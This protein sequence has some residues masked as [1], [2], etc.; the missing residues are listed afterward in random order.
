VDK[1]IHEVVELIQPQCDRRRVALVVETADDMPP[2]PM[3]TAA[4]HQ[5]LMNVLTNAVEAAPERKGRITIRSRFLAEDSEAEISI[6][7]NG[8]GIGEHM[9]DKVFE[10]FASSKGQRG[11]GL[12][13]A[14]TRKLV[15]EHGGRIVLEP[16]AVEGD[17]GATFTITLPSDHSS[18]SAGETKLPQPL[19]ADALRD[20]F[21]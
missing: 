6:S 4:M 12:G 9:R 19:R 18:L 5:A 10:P 8:P 1:L 2:I 21:E 17:R 20:E 13:L 16:A 3:D 15:A 11:T 14:V 7:D